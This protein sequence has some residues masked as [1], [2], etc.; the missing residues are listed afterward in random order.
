VDVLYALG[1][2]SFTLYVKFNVLNYTGLINKKQPLSG[3]L[4]RQQQ[5][6]AGSPPDNKKAI[7]C[8]GIDQLLID[9]S[10]SFL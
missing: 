1:Y 10:L 2:A 5:K 8:L 6:L 9:R 3:F 4:P 7:T